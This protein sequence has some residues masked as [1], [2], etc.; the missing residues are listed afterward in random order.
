MRI[1]VIGSRDWTDSEAVRDAIVA[2]IPTGVESAVVV[3]GA[4]P[5]GADYHADTWGRLLSGL[6]VETYPAAWTLHG[7]RAGF[8][9]NKAMVEA[10]ADVCLAFI[11]N[12]SRGAS[13]T[14]RL[15]E[16]AG[17]P[18]RYYREGGAA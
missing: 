8:L 14:A 11:K 17:I 6:S 1:L 7:K 16:E 15:A 4:C 2:T 3:H 13:M 18:V 5:T 10:G 9:R 12:N